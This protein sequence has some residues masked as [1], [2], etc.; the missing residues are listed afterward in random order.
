MFTNTLRSKGFEVER[1][2]ARYGQRS[3]DRSVLDDCA[4]NGFVILTQDRDFVR[5]ADDHEQGGVVMYTDSRSL[6]E[7]PLEAVEAIE[8]IDRHYDAEEIRDVVEWLD[9]WM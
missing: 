9:N 3:I 8:R 4:E 5:L 7:S 2:Q 6:L 1:A